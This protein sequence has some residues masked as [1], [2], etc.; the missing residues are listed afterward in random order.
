MSNATRKLRKVRHK[1][2]QSRIV[3]CVIMRMN[4]HNRQ[5]SSSI[6]VFKTN[7]MQV[8]N[9]QILAEMLF[10]RYIEQGQPQSDQDHPDEFPSHPQ[11]PPTLRAPESI[12]PLISIPNER[13]TH[14]R[15]LA[16]HGLILRPESSTVIRLWDLVDG[17]ILRV[18]GR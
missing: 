8:M 11:T 10:T 18:D 15:L 7:G 1:E 4:F 16:A 13:Q 3:G 17:E 6:T 9:C 14:T 2:P 5:F 12:E